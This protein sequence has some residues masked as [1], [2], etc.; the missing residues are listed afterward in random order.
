MVLAGLSK[1]LRAVLEEV[2]LEKALSRRG[3]VQRS[4]DR[5][6]QAE[7]ASVQMSPDGSLLLWSRSSRKITSTKREKEKRGQGRVPVGHFNPSGCHS[8]HNGNMNCQNHTSGLQRTL[9]PWCSYTAAV[10]SRS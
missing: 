8:A 9:W 2:T 5:A 10:K 3:T 1:S 6:L 7:G 4:G